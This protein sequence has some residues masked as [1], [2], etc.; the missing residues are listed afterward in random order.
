MRKKDVIRVQGYPVN[1]EDD[2]ISLTDMVKSKGDDARPADVIRNWLNTKNTIEFLGTWEALNS[3]IFNVLGFQHVKD[4]FNEMPTL[5]VKS[6][7]ENTGAIGIYSKEGK[8]GGTY[9]HKDIAFEFGSYI[10]PI[11]KLY[12]IKEFQRLKEIESNANNIEWNVRRLLAKAQYHVQTDA[13]KKYK[14]PLSKLPEDKLFLVY[15]EEGDI[16]N[17]ALFGFTARQWREANPELAI[18]GQN[19]REYA[20]INELSVMQSLEGINADMIKQNLPFDERLERL[21]EIAKEQL[22]V[23]DRIAPHNN[24][25]KNA[26]GE[27][28]PFL[29]TDRKGMF[30]AKPMVKKEEQLSDF[31]SKLKKALNHNPKDKPES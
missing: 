11:F 6:W 14:L 29:G 30:P 20:S 19:A 7:I 15:A 26:D 21:R 27:F 23:L 8:T 18:K 3:N 1:V 17:L 10:S 16:L 2:Y 5:S 9:A 24:L 4:N 22:Q 31:D 28:Q 13:V 25:R 12:L